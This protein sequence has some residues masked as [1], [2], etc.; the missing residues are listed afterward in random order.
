MRSFY[1]RGQRANQ[2]NPLAT[3]SNIAVTIIQ[4]DNVL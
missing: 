3:N 1:S 4:A 2:T